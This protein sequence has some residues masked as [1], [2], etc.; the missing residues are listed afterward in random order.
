M[1]TDAKTIAVTI[2]P[3]LRRSKVGRGQNGASAVVDRTDSA[4]GGV[5]SSA[6]ARPDPRAI[7]ATNEAARIVR[8]KEEP[9]LTAPS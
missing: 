6:D 8:T 9:E 3:L 5:A 2:K 1:L 7:E 4:L